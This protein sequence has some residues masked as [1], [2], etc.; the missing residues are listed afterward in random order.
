MPIGTGLRAG[1]PL[2]GAA[3]QGRVA[4]QRRRRLQAHP[5]CFAHHAAEKPDVQL[6]RRYRQWVVHCQ[7]LHL[8]A[9]RTQPRKALA[10]HQRVG[11][12]YGRHHFGDACGHQRVAARAGAAVVG[13][14]L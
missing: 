5:R 7:H 11:V 12:G 2:A 4:V 14:G 3:G 13:A 9:C 1:D 6:P 10:A 8:Y